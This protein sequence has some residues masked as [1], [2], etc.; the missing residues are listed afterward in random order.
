MQLREIPLEVFVDV[1]KPLTNPVEGKGFVYEM[2]GEDFETIRK[3]FQENRKKVWS[4]ID[5]GVYGDFIVNGLQQLQHRKGVIITE[6]TDDTAE[7]LKIIPPR[8][9]NNV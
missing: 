3:A 6:L 2:Y 5:G 4:L 7:Y 8:G 9:G 1:Y